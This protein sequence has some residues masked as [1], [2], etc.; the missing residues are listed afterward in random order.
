MKRP[1]SNIIGVAIL[2]TII[3]STQAAT[4][5]TKISISQ[6]LLK[7]SRSL[8]DTNTNLADILD[9]RKGKNDEY[10]EESCLTLLTQATKFDIDASG[11]LNV[12][13]FQSYYDSLAGDNPWA[14]EDMTAQLE[15]GDSVTWVSTTKDLFDNL[16]QNCHDV[17][18]GPEG[19]ADDTATDDE[20][21]PAI[22]ET[23]PTTKGS[24][25]YY[26]HIVWTEVKLPGFTK[27]IEGMKPSKDESEYIKNFCDSV[28]DAMEVDGIELGID[29][30]EPE[31][32][33]T[34]T[35]E[36]PTVVENSTEVVIDEIVVE[37]SSTTVAATTEATQV[38]TEA[39]EEEEVV[40]TTT[41]API[42]TQVVTTTEPI[43]Q[44]ITLSFIG[45]TGGTS[46][47]TTV[48]TD[49]VTD[50]MWKVIFDSL[51][52]SASDSTRKKRQ[53]EWDFGAQAAVYF[54]S[55]TMAVDDVG[56]N[57]YFICMIYLYLQGYYS[58]INH[59]HTTI[60]CPDGLE[61]AAEEDSCIEFTYTLTPLPDGPLTL[62]L[63]TELTTSFDTAVN[64]N[65]ALYDALISEY[66]DTEIVGVGS[67]GK[68]VPMTS[69]RDGAT[70]NASFGQAIKI[71]EQQDESSSSS[72][73]FPVGGI[74]GIA[75]A[76][77]LVA[78]LLAAVVVKKRRRNKRQLDDSNISEDL[79][80]NEVN[81]DA[82]WFDE[83]DA[84]GAGRNRTRDGMKVQ[85]GSS[86]AALGVASTVATRL[87]T[88]D[89][90][91]M[92]TKKQSWAKDEPVI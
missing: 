72:S 32:V 34:T 23:E 66:P 77:L 25:D 56:K 38:A 51:D 10:K 41:V 87:S 35:T 73:S 20:T 59:F 15:S 65:G 13:E 57:F 42:T 70:A 11:G 31:V 3:S 71:D 14:T 74:I 67:P 44:P 50:A 86:L 58:L 45:S 80:A 83:E 62:E 16:R 90:E 48:N 47:A 49:D 85:P 28:V 21:L 33:T 22:S 17:F 53:L 43:V 60:A 81:A 92:V 9:P 4:T 29:E 27:A 6:P 46:D 30:D 26:E 40:T 78:L 18:L 63:A 54:E 8:Q 24:A 1:N 75:C 76:C 69:D 5:Q 37:E 61:Y 91:V 89:T 82:E 84:D 79:E 55:V 52:S 88:G 64:T 68:G 2:S 36:A 19:C 39:I 12:L 7:G